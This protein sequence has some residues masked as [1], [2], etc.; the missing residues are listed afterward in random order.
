MAPFDSTARRDSWWSRHFHNSAKGGIRRYMKLDKKLA[1]ALRRVTKEEEKDLS[2]IHKEVDDL[3]I[4][5]KETQV[6][7][8]YLISVS[9]LAESFAAEESKRLQQSLLMRRYKA[10]MAR[11]RFMM[12]KAGK[13]YTDAENISYRKQNE[14]ARVDVTEAKI[15]FKKYNDF[16]NELNK[17][18]NVLKNFNEHAKSV[19][20]IHEN[21]IK[22]VE[23]EYGEDQQIIKVSA[24]E[25]SVILD[26]ATLNPNAA[27]NA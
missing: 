24:K 19:K 13:K 17:L 7:Y 25:H 23:I 1:W 18:M 22:D 21:L 12:F 2:L 9:K 15:Q 26:P 27:A 4:M 11:F 14:L 3:H 20:T 5:V 6:L 10:K 8:D 16:L